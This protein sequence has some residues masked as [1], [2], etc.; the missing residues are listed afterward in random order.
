MHFTTAIL[1]TLAATALAAPPISPPSALDTPFLYSLPPTNN[2]TTSTPSEAA[3]PLL[4]KRAAGGHARHIMATYCEHS[5]HTT[6]CQAWKFTAGTCYGLARYWNDR[7]SSF[8]PESS[9]TACSIYEGA[10]C[11]GRNVRLSWPG[12]N[13]L[14]N[15]GMNDKISSVKCYM[16]S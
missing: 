10:E 16:K 5:Y 13:A 9:G 15:E 2:S 12:S 11:T 3:E 4:P 7:I 8:Y 1:A 6:P 14:A